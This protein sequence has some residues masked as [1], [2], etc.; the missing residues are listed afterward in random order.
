MVVLSA[1][2][3]RRVVVLAAGIVSVM[4]ISSG[5][6]HVIHDTPSDLTFTSTMSAL[7]VLVA[8][9]AIASSVIRRRRVDVQAVLE[10][11]G[12]YAHRHF[13]L[14]NWVQD[15]GIRLILARS[16]RR[17]C[18]EWVGAS[19][20]A[21]STDGHDSAHRLRPQIRRPQRGSGARAK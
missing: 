3:A 8:P 2:G 7:L 11:R 20:V 6:F 14:R 12:Q 15:A 5:V 19:V 18:A 4:A 16:A 17:L 1:S 13:V 9:V 10:R 21:E